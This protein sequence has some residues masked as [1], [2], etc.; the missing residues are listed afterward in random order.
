MTA[1]QDGGR[2]AAPAKLHG[3]GSRSVADTTPSPKRQQRRLP[4]PSLQFEP[5][6]QAPQPALTATAALRD[7]P[8]KY[9]TWSEDDQFST[10]KYSSET[11]INSTLC[12]QKLRTLVTD[13]TCTCF[14]ALTT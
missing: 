11:L 9:E 3:R 12:G 13:I 7:K 1:L 14:N 2:R 4:Q 10:S 8:V 6:S 5:L